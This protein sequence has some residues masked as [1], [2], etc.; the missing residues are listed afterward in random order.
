MDFEV[1]QEEFDL[2][3]KILEEV[4]IGINFNDD[5]KKEFECQ[6]D[7]LVFT[8][9]EFKVFLGLLKKVFYEEDYHEFKEYLAFFIDPSWD[10]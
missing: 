2:I 8:E 1:T 10:V 4:A 6:I 9:K 7:K 3:A 5:I